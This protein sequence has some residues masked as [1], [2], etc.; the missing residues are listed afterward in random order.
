MTL[1]LHVHP[2][3]MMA[4]KIPSLQERS[5]HCPQGGGQTPQQPGLCIPGEEVLAMTRPSRARS[6]SIAG[7]GFIKELKAVAR[8]VSG[9]VLA[10]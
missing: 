3:P 7:L 6:A 9:L 4:V 8:G 5:G 1:S 10:A 2:I